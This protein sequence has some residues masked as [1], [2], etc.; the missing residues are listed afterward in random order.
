MSKPTAPIHLTTGYGT[1]DVTL[2]SLTLAC[3][4]G[5]ASVLALRKLTKINGCYEIDGCAEDLHAILS[6]YLAKT[7]V[8]FVYPGE[9]PDDARLELLGIRFPKGV[10]P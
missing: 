1:T 10:R 3:V 2:P 5:A 6:D 9:I 7:M 4:M 8:R